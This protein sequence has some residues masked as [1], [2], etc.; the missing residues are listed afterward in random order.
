MAVRNRRYTSPGP[1]STGIRV[2]SLAAPGALTAISL[3]V[4]RPRLTLRSPPESV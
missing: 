4:E 1:A 3:L 2:Q